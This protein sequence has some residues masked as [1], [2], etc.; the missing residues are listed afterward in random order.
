[1]ILNQ[2][3]G[4]QAMLKSLNA[5]KFSTPLFKSEIMTKE[6]D[7]NDN[8]WSRNNDDTMSNPDS[9]SKLVTYTGNTGQLYVKR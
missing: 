7:A 4:G 9:D 5:F 1:M 6:K 8:G 2:C 3:T